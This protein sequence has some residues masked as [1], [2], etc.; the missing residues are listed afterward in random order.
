MD[1]EIYVRYPLITPFADGGKIP[2]WAKEAGFSEADYDFLINVENREAES[3]Y[4]WLY[5]GKYSD[6]SE[7]DYEARKITDYETEIIERNG[8]YWLFFKIN[9]PYS[10]IERVAAADGKE[11]GYK[12]MN[13]D[14]V[15]RIMHEFKEGDLRDSHGTLVT[16]RKQA[17]AIALSM[18]RRRKK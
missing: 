4:L 11:L 2:Q 13:K 8:E 1:N 6:M 5:V 18:G 7:A 17:I 9:F 10:S 15:A 12:G 3:D 16:D 14:I